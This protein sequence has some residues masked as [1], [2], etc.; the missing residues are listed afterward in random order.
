MSSQTKF[1]KVV[2]DGSPNTIEYEYDDET[3]ASIAVIQAICALK[4]VDPIRA[5][6][7][8]GFVLHEHVDPEALDTLLADGSGTGEIV[9]SF[10]ISNGDAYSVDVAD[11]G[12]ITVQQLP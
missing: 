9:V 4:G 11:D 5:P 7:E 8:L 2:S 12:R 3:P 10:E 6:T 1:H